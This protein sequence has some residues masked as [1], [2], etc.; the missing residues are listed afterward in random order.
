MNLIPLPT[1]YGI[2]EKILVIFPGALGDFI[3]FLPA[4]QK[5]AEGRRVDL[6]ARSEYAALTP[7][8]VATRSLECYEINR[9]FV[10][11]AEQD[12]RLREF[13]DS[14]RN[15][16]SWMASSQP[17]FI[18]QL[19]NL[20]RNKPFIFPFRPSRT[21][22]HMIDY[23]LSCVG[24][25]PAEEVFPLI[26]LRPEAVSWSEDFWQKK[27][28]TGG[29]VL[30]LAPGSGAAEKNWPIDHYNMVAEWW[31][32]SVGG[33]SIVVLG[34]V[35]EE[36]LKAAS[37]WRDVLVVKDLLLAQLAAL[38]VRSD[39]YLGNDSGVTHLAA[40]VGAPTFALF[41][42]TDLLQWKPRGRQ[43][44]VISQNAGCSPCTNSAMKRC[45]HHNCLITLNARAVITILQQAWRASFGSRNAGRGN[46]DKGGGRDYSD[47]K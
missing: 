25:T 38:L 19:G 46:L 9:L 45:L 36:K 28:L 41:G 37:I 39:L 1:L 10:P 35:E 44:T 26:A 13:F 18:R 20:S 14:Y 29:P 31:E 42:P 23:Y 32:K 6:L 16:Y 34:P 47:Y 17:Q 11:G 8:N 12:E 15:I 22:M 5:L 2:Q 27:R 21:R 7:E 43:V 40:A 3:C 30:V 24:M 4:L 33:K